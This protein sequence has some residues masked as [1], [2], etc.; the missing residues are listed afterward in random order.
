MLF[1]F[2]PYHSVCDGAAVCEYQVLDGLA[3]L[4]KDVLHKPGQDP[5]LSQNLEKNSV[6]LNFGYSIIISNIVLYFV[7]GYKN[8]Q[9]NVPTRCHIVG[10]GQFLKNCK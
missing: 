1:A 5:S 8:Q 3:D 4:W 6:I 9:L 2:E 7:L 10:S